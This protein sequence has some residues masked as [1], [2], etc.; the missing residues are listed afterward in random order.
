MC[1]DIKLIRISIITKY[2]VSFTPFVDDNNEQPEHWVGL[3]DLVNIINNSLKTAIQSHLIDRLQ[4]WLQCLLQTPS[5][6]Q[7][8]LH[9]W[10][11]EDYSFAIIFFML[12]AIVLVSNILVFDQSFMIFQ[13]QLS[14]KVKNGSQQ[15]KSYK[16][17]DFFY[18]RCEYVKSSEMQS[19][20]MVIC[21]NQGGSFEVKILKYP[22][23]KPTI[24]WINPLG[25]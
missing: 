2:L 16:I 19:K 4:V 6:L 22:V 3:I 10:K 24:N 9:S 17:S 11:S 14:N 25:L 1:K 8:W 12:I 23:F 20:M 7:I 18:T 13:C 15:N 21:Q 5:R